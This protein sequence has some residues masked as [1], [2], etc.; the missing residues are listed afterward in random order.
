M[1]R[2]KLLKQ[3][4]GKADEG[5]AA[6]LM[7]SPIAV[8]RSA[9]TFAGLSLGISRAGV[10]SHGLMLIA[11]VHDHLEERLDHVDQRLGH[12][13]GAQRSEQRQILG[14][15]E[16]VAGVTVGVLERASTSRDREPG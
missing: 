10:G 8:T 16:V 9:A 12:P 13:Q 4:G 6:L 15:E 5:A 1:R 7:P 14:L 3:R 11:Q 2:G